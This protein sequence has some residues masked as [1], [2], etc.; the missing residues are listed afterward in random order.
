MNGCEHAPCEEVTRAG[1][2]LFGNGHPEQ[3]VIVRLCN[4]ERRLTVITRLSWII[5][6]GVWA[7]LFKVF[8]SWIDALLGG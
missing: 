1:K 6:C 3:S 4:V 5:A 7:V 8:G 2:A